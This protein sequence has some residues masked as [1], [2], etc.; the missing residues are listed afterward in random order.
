MRVERGKERRRRVGRRRKSRG[1]IV[2]RLLAVAYLTLAERKDGK[3]WRKRRKR[4]ERKGERKKGVNVIHHRGNTM[5]RKKG[6]KK[7]EKR[8]E[9]KEKE[10]KEE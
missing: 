6:K 8:K 2:P 9:R 7:K 1:V 5:E 4:R 3:E 10:R